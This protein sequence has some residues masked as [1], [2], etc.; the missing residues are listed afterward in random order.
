MQLDVNSLKWKKKKKIE[1]IAK[2]FNLISVI[3]EFYVYSIN[4]TLR[5]LKYTL[6]SVTGSHVLRGPAF[7]F[8]KLWISLA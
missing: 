2:L 4:C 1:G 5:K 7:V 8:G 3:L 6:E